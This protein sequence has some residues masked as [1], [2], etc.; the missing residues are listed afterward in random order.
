MDE[1]GTSIEGQQRLDDVPRPP[2]RAS[3]W[4][5]ARVQAVVP[6]APDAVTLRL[7]LTHAQTFLPGQYYNVRLP[8]VGHRRPIQRAYSVAS[9]PEPDSSVIDLG[10]REVR[11]GLLSP[12]LVRLRPGDRL[13]VRGPYGRFTWDAKDHGQV[14]LVGAGSGVVPLMSMVRYAVQR[15]RVDPLVFVCS[16]STYHQALY[17]SEL[18]SLASQHSWLRV[19]PCITRDPTDSRAAFRQRVDALVLL[20][21][22]DGLRPVAAYLCGPPEMVGAVRLAL[23]DLD[24]DPATIKTEKYD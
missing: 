3:G 12:A 13:A 20:A 10:V 23:I 9:S 24:L 4:Q 5:E 21:S 7:R 22:L 6:E 14:L 18:A 17:R 15:R 19:V 8:A 11:D 16:S 2:H 1:R